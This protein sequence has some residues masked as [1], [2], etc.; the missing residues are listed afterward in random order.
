MVIEK[1]YFFF[2]PLL[3][4]L[5]YQI[6]SKSVA[7]TAIIK[8]IEVSSITQCYFHCWKKHFDCHAIGFLPHQLNNPNFQHTKCYMLKEDINGHGGEAKTMEV[9]VSISCLLTCS[10][11]ILLIVLNMCG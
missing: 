4:V 6:F 1:I 11:K 7:V 5:R 9:I 8:T 3:L 2:F 10:T